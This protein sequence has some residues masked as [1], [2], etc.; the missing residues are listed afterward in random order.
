MLPRF[1]TYYTAAALGN[2]RF[3][4]AAN[5]NARILAF[6][7]ALPEFGRRLVGFRSDAVL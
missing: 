7:E 1:N 3:G 6:K 5:R 2:I 4:Y